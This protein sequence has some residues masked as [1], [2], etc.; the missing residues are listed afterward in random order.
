MAAEAGAASG[1]SLTISGWPLSRYPPN[2]A[3]QRDTGCI[4]VSIIQQRWDLP[5][6]D[7]FSR[8]LCSEI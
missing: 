8:E 2:Q 1:F 7:H 4:A 6:P 5:P 3:A